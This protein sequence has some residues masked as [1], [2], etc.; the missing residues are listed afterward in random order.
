MIKAIVREMTET[1]GNDGSWK[2][3]C[4]RKVYVCEMERLQ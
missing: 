2:I 4:F 1:P 3:K